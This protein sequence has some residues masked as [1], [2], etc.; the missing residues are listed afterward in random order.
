M[1]HRVDVRTL[2]TCD[3]DLVFKFVNVNEKPALLPVFRLSARSEPESAG[4]G[5]LHRLDSNLIMME[6]KF[7]NNPGRGP[8]KSFSPFRYD[9]LSDFQNRNT[10]HS[11]S[12]ITLNRGN[13]NKRR[14]FNKI[15]AI[16]K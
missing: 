7:I 8:D 15:A 10:I 13:P 11:C 1:V 14:N 4:I 9:I 2:P 16:E 12:D 3:L 6:T 5:R